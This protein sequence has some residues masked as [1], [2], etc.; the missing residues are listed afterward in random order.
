MSSA[1]VS[2]KSSDSINLLDFDRKGLAAF[3]IGI[4]EK[5]FRATQLLKWIYQE[6]V[7]DFDHMTNLINSLRDYLEKHCEFTPP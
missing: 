7:T 4:G 3:F 5:P 1:T 2:A 6:N